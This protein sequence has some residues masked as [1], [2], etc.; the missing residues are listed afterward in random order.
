MPFWTQFDDSPH[1]VRTRTPDGRDLLFLTGTAG[2]GLKG[3]GQTWAGDDAYHL[4]GPFWRRIDSV[5]PMA[6]IGS[7]YN[8]HT[9]VDA[10]WA[11]DNCRWVNY[12]GRILLVVFCVVSDIDGWLYRFNYQVTAL[13]LL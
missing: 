8:E 3:Q 11:T 13:G 6:S 12:G 1:E 7:A 4:V 10:G 9:A 2:F 5:A